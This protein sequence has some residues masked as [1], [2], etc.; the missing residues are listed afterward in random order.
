MT[1]YEAGHA[2]KL[3]LLELQSYVL[4]RAPINEELGKNIDR[5]LGAGAL[6]AQSAAFL[7]DQNVTFH[8]FNSNRIGYDI[9]VISV[10]VPDK[11]HFTGF[12]DGHVS[13]EYKS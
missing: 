5:L 13:E 12:S 10:I 1:R 11:A 4:Y 6:S 2:L 8:G 3:V 9:P 7:R